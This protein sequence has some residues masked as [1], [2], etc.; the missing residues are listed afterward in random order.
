MYKNE[1]KKQKKTKTKKSEELR[2]VEDVKSN[3]LSPN[4]IHQKPSNA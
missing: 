3:G 1:S 4:Y 2:H